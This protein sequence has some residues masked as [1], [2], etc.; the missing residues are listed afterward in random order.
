MTN[1]DDNNDGQVKKYYSTN[2]DATAIYV[3]T[4]KDQKM[5][6]DTIATFKKASHLSALLTEAITKSGRDKYDYEAAYAILSGSGYFSLSEAKDVTY[7]H[8]D[9]S[10]TVDV[11]IIAS[12]VG[13]A[14][15]PEMQAALT[16]VIKDFGGAL[17]VSGTL[18]KE[19]QKKVKRIL[20]AED[21]MGIPDISIQMYFL[22]RDEAKTFIKTPCSTSSTDALTF[23]YHTFEVRF[24]DPDWFDQFTDDFLSSKDHDALLTQFINL[25]PK[26]VV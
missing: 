10:V 20:W 17:T 3:T 26:P 1:S 5:N 22:S 21:E 2:H 12:I 6:E 8:T 15:A 14:V 25:I 16:S 9:F 23:T 13:D 7:T 24:V 4:E 11:G 19:S 18:D